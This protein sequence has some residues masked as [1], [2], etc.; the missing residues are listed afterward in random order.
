MLYEKLTY[1]I[2]SALF[3]VHNAI[4]PG[5]KEM[6]YHNALVEEFKARSI[7]FVSKKR[8]PITYKGKRVGTY[9]PDF[10]VD[11]KVIIELKSVPIMPKAHETQLFYYL[12]GSEYKLGLLVNFG[13]DKVDI[14]RKVFDTARNPRLSADQRR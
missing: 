8:L 7:A 12:K 9:E 5:F 4:G 14:R 10:I 6:V 2:R 13:C 1:E 3:E 11:E